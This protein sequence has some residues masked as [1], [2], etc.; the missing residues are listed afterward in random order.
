MNK[1]LYAGEIRSQPIFPIMPEGFMAISKPQL[2]PIMPEWYHS[3]T[4]P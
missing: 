3:V 1:D 2:Y 4:K